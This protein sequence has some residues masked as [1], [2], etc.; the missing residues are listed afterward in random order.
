MIRRSKSIFDFGPYKYVL[1]I[2]A[3]IMCLILIT[4]SLI[5]ES[6]QL[7]DV[8]DATLDKRKDGDVKTGRQNEKRAS[9]NAIQQGNVLNAIQQGNVVKSTRKSIAIRGISSRHLVSL[10][11]DEKLVYAKRNDSDRGIH[12]IV[13]NEFNGDVMATKSFDTCLNMNMQLY[14]KL[15][16]KDMRPDTIIISMVK[17]DAAFSLTEVGRDALKALGSR[18]IDQLKLRGR[19]IFVTR[20]GKTL[21]ESVSNNP[22]KGMNADPLIL[23]MSFPLK[24]ASDFCQYNGSYSPQELK[25][26]VFCFKYVGF[27]SICNCTHPSPIQF[28]PAELLG[29]RMKSVPI[30]IVA[31]NRPHYLHRMLQKL[32]SNQ[33]VTR[34]M[35]TVYVDGYYDQVIALLDVLGVRFVENARARCGD[36][37]KIHQSYKHMLDSTAARNLQAEFMMIIEEDLLVSDDFMDYFNQLLPVLSAD[38]SLLCISA[39]N[40][41]GFKHSTNDPSMVYRVETMPGL[42]WVLKRDIYVKEFAPIWPGLKYGADWD[43]WMR[44]VHIRKSRECLIPDIPRTFHF[45]KIGTHITDYGGTDDEYN[46]LFITTLNTKTGNRFDVDTLHKDSYEKHMHGLVKQAQVLDHTIDPCNKN[47]SFIPSTQNGLY[48]MYIKWRHNGDAE[49]WLNLAKCFKLWS[50]D[51]RGVHKHMW[52]FWL[53]ENHV[54]V[55]SN[56]SPYFIYKPKDVEPIFISNEHVGNKHKFSMYH[57]QGYEI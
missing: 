15:Y 22:V 39:W 9:K 54:I 45:G 32:L 25:R 7:D 21:H 28:R 52:R 44:Q 35:V 57:R 5:E 47:T 55:V 50:V 34:D 46:N 4:Y 3:I 38:E 37:C 24:D 29:N 51:V 13:L 43:L 31:S 30:S 11:I 33:G 26:R 36:E 19:W 48:V 27:N 42:G 53:Q 14:L 17:D 49:T 56:R 10:H 12:L 8:H 20:N 41:H 40:D 2:S 1:G 6:E 18:K 23:K 16:L